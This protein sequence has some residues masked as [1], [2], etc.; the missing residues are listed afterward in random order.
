MSVVMNL[1]APPEGTCNYPL[2]E[3]AYESQLA[4]FKC[5]TRIHDSEKLKAHLLRI[6][7]KIYERFRYPCVW[8]FDFVRGKVIN[9]P[10]FPEILTFKKER[11]EEQN[12]F[13]DLGASV[14]SDVRQVI[15]E[16]WKREDILAIEI[17][18]EAINL[19][20]EMF[21]DSDRPIPCFIGN[22]FDPNIF[23]PTKALEKTS[24]RIDLF[25]LKDMNLLKRRVSFI[26]CHYLFHLFDR[27]DQERLANYCAL[28][29]SDEPGSSIFGTHKG[30][31][32]QGPQSLDHL[33][34][35]YWYNHSVESWVQMWENIFNPE[36][37][38]IVAELKESNS[39]TQYKFLH[40]SEKILWM[41]WSVTRL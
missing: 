38:K 10:L 16:G 3:P 33:P 39:Q 13:L 22:I 5:A 15:S 18:Q 19:G 23:D 34:G 32:E 2:D 20:Y 29:L 25:S 27:D 21:I 30:S 26:S 9:H 40:P 31:R 35:T 12:I 8:N 41:S 7:K 36:T 24:S 14:A 1:P 11:Q 6:Q 17:D 28:L 4:F 37:V